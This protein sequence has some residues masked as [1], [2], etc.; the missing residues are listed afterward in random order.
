[1]N[2][3]SCSAACLPLLL[4]GAV[5]AHAQQPT[6]TPDHPTATTA[7]TTQ[8][9]ARLRGTVTDIFGNPV[10]GAFVA[11]QGTTLRAITGRTGLYLIEGVPAGRHTVEVHSVGYALARVEVEVRDGAQGPPHRSGPHPPRRTHR[12][13][14]HRRGHRP[15]RA[16]LQKFGLLRRHENRHCAQRCAP[17]GGLR[18]ERTCARPGRIDGQRCGQKHQRRGTLLFLQRFFHPRLPRHGQSQFGQSAQRHAST[19]Q[20]VATILAGQRGA[21]RGHQGTGGHPL[22]QCCAGRGDQP[23]H[24]EAARIQ[25]PQCDPHRRQFQHHPGLRRLHRPAQCTGFAALSPQPGL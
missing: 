25:P 12:Q 4:F 3:F 23:R 18:H 6:T 15:K 19:D 22:R 8:T 16:I 5:S 21:R 20:F 13:S 17:I 11:I 7:R 2:A 1:M 24:Q 14:A 9:A 10:G